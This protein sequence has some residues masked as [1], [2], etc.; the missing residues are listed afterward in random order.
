ME[1]SSGQSR[2]VGE[3]LMQAAGKMK[4]GVFLVAVAESSEAILGLS[5]PAER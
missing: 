4:L 2:R 3:A 5:W 1:G